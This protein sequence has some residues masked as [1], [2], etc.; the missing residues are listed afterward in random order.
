M[1]PSLPSLPK[2]FDEFCD[3]L[4][5]KVKWSEKKTDFTKLIFDF[6]SKLTNS[7]QPPFLGV[8]EYMTLDFVMRHKMPE[9]S[10]NTL[11]LALEH[12]ISQRKPNDVISSEVQHLVDIK[13]KYKIGIFYPSVGDEENLRIKIKEKIEQGKSLSVPWE[14][15]LFIFG[16]PTT[17]G[18]ERCILFKATHFIWNKQYD[19]QN[20]ESKQLKDKFI[21]QKNK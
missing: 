7:T 15:Y 9:Y 3:F 19:H 8:R 1:N 13:A 12:E 14:E 10:F 17:Q 20:L 2:I 18:G 6:F 11:E 5:E 4:E 21:K 16:S